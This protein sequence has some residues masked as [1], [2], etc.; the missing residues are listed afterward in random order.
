VQNQLVVFVTQLKFLIVAR[1]NP[2]HVPLRIQLFKFPKLV[3]VAVTRVLN[4]LVLFL[5]NSLED[6][7]VESIVVALYHINF[8]STI[9]VP[10]LVVAIVRRIYHQLLGIFL[11]SLRNIDQQLGIGGDNKTTLIEELVL[12]YLLQ[13]PNIP[14]FCV[15]DLFYRNL[16]V[17][18]TQKFGLCPTQ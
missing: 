8:P 16:A 5:I 3:Q 4:Y 6:V 10:S 17:V 14:L 12:L 15:F 13:H 1:R 2:E 18:H 7:K 11:R 9:D